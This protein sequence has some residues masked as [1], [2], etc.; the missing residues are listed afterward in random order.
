[1]DSLPAPGQTCYPPL[2]Q[3]LPSSLPKSSPSS[4][5]IHIACVAAVVA[6]MYSASHDDSYNPLLER[7]RAHQAIAEEEHFAS[8]ALPHVDVAGEICYAQL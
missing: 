4:R 5:A 2:A 6:A 1:V 3:P 8:G 7:L